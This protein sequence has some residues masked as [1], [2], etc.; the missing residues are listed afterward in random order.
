[1]IY[2]DHSPLIP[3]S[4]LDEYN[5]TSEEIWQALAALL[6][7]ATVNIHIP[8]RAMA[9]YPATI[10]AAEDVQWKHERCKQ[11][12]FFPYLPDSFMTND[13][14][15]ARCRTQ[16]AVRSTNMSKKEYLKDLDSLLDPKLTVSHAFIEERKAVL[17]ARL[18]SQGLQIPPIPPPAGIGV[19]DHRKV[20]FNWYGTC[21]ACN[22]ICNRLSPIPA[23]VSHVV[24][25]IRHRTAKL[26][27][28]LMALDFLLV[29]P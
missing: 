17:L 19:D 4:F 8:Y 1:M 12:K 3:H 5:L 16:N 26:S 25:P 7:D 22:W 23:C 21:G 11:M 28:R 6:N 9:V 20:D 15:R 14:P 29:M 27:K 2:T 10:I 24:K 13:P 18:R